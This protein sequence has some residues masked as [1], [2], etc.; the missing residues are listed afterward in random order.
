MPEVLLVDDEQHVLDGLALHLRRRF[1]ATTANSGEEAVELL[2]ADPSRFAV[3]V[4]DMRMPGMDGAAFLARAHAVAPDATRM[5]LTGHAEMDAAIAAVNEGRIF[6][7]L[8]KP[9]PAAVL[10]PAIEA[11]VEQHRL[12]TAQKVLL[13]ETF[14]GSIAVLTSLLELAQ[15]RAF[16][17]AGRVSRR[18]GELARHTG[19]D[20]WQ[21]EIAA[22]LSQIAAVMLPPDVLD[23]MESDEPLQ[24]ED[25]DRIRRLPAMTA[26]LLARIPRLEGVVGILR[27]VES[28]DPGVPWE[29]R[30]LGVLL[31][32][33]SLE[34]RGTKPVQAVRLVRAR[35]GARDREVLDEIDVMLEDHAA[36]HS[37]GDCA[38][39]ALLPGMV[40]AEDVRDPAG[41]LLFARGYEVT[42]GLLEQ[43]RATLERAGVTRAITVEVA[44]RATRAA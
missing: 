15:P 27:G 29:S 7:F 41:N 12:V 6:R 2:A 26:D 40:L 36:T 1:A 44:A 17:R 28:D 8:T 13:R 4:S 23:R 9:C 18:V 31:E 33:D 19:R 11:A 14:A 5:L 32:M 37:V 10:V 24:A 22:Q 16:S 3:V 30:A 20:A 34:Q 42:G 21:V 38:P 39:G 43:V 25:L 35:R